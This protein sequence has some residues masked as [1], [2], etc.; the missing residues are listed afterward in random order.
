[1]VNAVRKDSDETPYLH[2]LIRIFPF[3]IFYLLVMANLNVK[4]DDSGQF[5]LP[6]RADDSSVYIYSAHMA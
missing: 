3:R 1:M 4:S 5:T 6:R 2:S